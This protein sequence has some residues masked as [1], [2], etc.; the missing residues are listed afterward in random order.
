MSKIALDTN[1]LVYLYDENFVAKR[2]VA[3]DLIAA[4]PNIPAQVVSEFLNVSKRLL[5]ISKI[6][7]I[8]KCNQVFRNCTILPTTQI[9][10]NKAEELIIRY[11]FQIFDAIIIATALQ[12]NCTTLYSEDMHHG[13][14]VDDLLSITNPFV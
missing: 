2:T 4:N 12:A 9:T 3:D 6:D 13:V 11:D 10:L 8:K 14:V 5:H 1:I 7:L